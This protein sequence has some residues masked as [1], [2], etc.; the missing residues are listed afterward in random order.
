MGAPFQISAIHPLRYPSL[1]PSLKGGL[2]PSCK[3]GERFPG[4][5]SVFSPCFLR[6]SNMLATV[7]HRF[8]MLHI[9][10]M[11]VNSR[12]HLFRQ[13][14]FSLDVPR[15]RL[16]YCQPDCPPRS[17]SMPGGPPV[18]HRWILPGKPTFTPWKKESCFVKKKNCKF[19][20]LQPGNIPAA[21]ITRCFLNDFGM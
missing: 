15:N 14:R 9:A 18:T 6:F 12:T 8:H 16:L 20:V 4:V 19:A 7:F 17:R 13:P 3:R 1:Y 10:C 11:A 2:L 5:F 21:G